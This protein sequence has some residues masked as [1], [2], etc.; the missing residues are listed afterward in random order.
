MSRNAVYPG[1][2]DPIT[3]GHQDL[4]RRAAG[5][6]D[7]VV[8]AIAANTNKTP[9]FSLEQR[10]S[11]A[12]QVL[13]DVPNVEVQGY[14]GLTVDFA[15]RNGITVI[16]RGLRAVSDFEFEFQLA[17]MSRHLFAGVETV[18]LTP[19]EQFTF[20]SSTLVREIAIF[21][22]RCVRVRPSDRRRGTQEDEAGL[23]RRQT[24]RA[25][26][27]GV[28]MKDSDANRSNR[29][30]ICCL[31]A[32]LL[33]SQWALADEAHKPPVAAIASAY[34]L[35]S[36]AGFEILAAGGNAFDAAVAVS[37][38]LE[39]SEPRG[40]GLGGGGFYLLHRSSDGLDLLIDAREVAPAAATRDMFL[41]AD[42]KP[43]PG[44][45]TDTALAAGIPGEGGRMGAPCGEV[46]PAAA[47][48][49]PATSDSP[50][51]Q[52]VSASTQRLAEDIGR[53]RPAFERSADAARIFLVARRRAAPGRLL[54]QPDLARSLSV[55]LQRRVRMAST[56]GLSPKSWWQE[57][58]SSAASGRWKTWRT[59]A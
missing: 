55:W 17:T 16:V 40:S 27:R 29:P 10:V 20:I 36:E 26:L 59:T 37:A 31:F 41:D 43:V 23:K 21:G 54:K 47:Q 8:V 33:F 15:R 7:R 19:Q 51:T 22:G 46:R 24:R 1:T 13:K 18:F 56:R 58:A 30:W 12:R 4:V 6:F 32:L 48:A 3:N 34:P 44:K 9:M 5:I 2:F 11:L 35:A 49:E 39:V 50:R 45:S 38:A 53:K 42:G 57:C 14:T 52:R 28:R 25:P